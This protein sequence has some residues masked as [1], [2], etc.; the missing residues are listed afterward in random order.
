MEPPSQTAYS[1]SVGDLTV[2][3]VLSLLSS[4]IKRGS[5]P[6][7]IVLPPARVTL[8]QLFAVVSVDL[9][10]TSLDYLVNAVNVEIVH[11]WVEEKLGGFVALDANADSLTIRHSEVLIVPAVILFRV[12]LDNALLFFDIANRLQSYE[13]ASSLQQEHRDGASCELRHLNGVG[14][15]SSIHSSNNLG[16][17]IARLHS[18]ASGVVIG[19]ERQ[20]HLALENEGGDTEG[21]ET[22]LGCPFVIFSGINVD[23]GHKKAIL[24]GSDPEFVV[25]C[26]MPDLLY[27]IPV[28]DDAVLDGV[29][30]VKAAGRKDLGANI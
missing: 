29:G 1:L 5:R 9:T 18:K 30:Q 26:V 10:A 8:A 28:R 19:I 23:L 7:N 21:L 17:T 16:H 25:E 20:H 24:L 4:T 6:D 14:E 22:D 15:D 11:L 12:L 13:H 3:S 2:A 27:G